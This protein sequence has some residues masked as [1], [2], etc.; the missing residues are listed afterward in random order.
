MITIDQAI[1][2]LQLMREQIGG[3]A[4]LVVRG[5]GLAA[6]D[7]DTIGS[8]NV[9]KGDSSKFVSRGGVPVATVILS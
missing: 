9:G 1:Q 6:R 3:G 4:A 5:N 7:I 8:C 2:Q